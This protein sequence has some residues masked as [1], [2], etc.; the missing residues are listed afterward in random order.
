MSFNPKNIISHLKST[1]LGLV[2]G[3]LVLVACFVLPE[4]WDSI[5]FQDTLPVLL[6]VVPFLLY[7][8]DKDGGAGKVLS[9]ALV[10]L[11]LF[12]ACEYPYEKK[13][14]A[15]RRERLKAELKIRELQHVVD[16]LRFAYL[17]LEVEQAKIQVQ[18]FKV[19]NQYEE[20]RIR[21]AL[22]ALDE[23]RDKR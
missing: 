9:I 5:K 13:Y 2:I 6:V 4:Y 19:L 17:Q 11:F 8:K 21:Y 23:L 12:S 15:E 16:S 18:H 14:Q 3:L 1:Y 22:P 20:Y 10:S 7:G